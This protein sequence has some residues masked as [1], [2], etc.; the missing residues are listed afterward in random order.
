[1]INIS[2]KKKASYMSGEGVH[3]VPA[4]LEFSNLDIYLVLKR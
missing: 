1:M 3:G 4:A 2:L